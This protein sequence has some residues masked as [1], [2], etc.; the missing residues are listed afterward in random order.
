MGTVA[1]LATI[2]SLVYLYWA[3]R[4]K[5]ICFVFGIISSS[6]WAFESFVHLQLVFDAG[7][8]LFYIVMSMVG[9]YRWKYG[10]KEDTERP[11]TT[12]SASQHIVFIIAGILASGVLMYMSRYIEAIA[13][14]RLDAVTTVFLVIGT[15]LLVDRRLYSWAYL[16]V[17]DVIYMY[18]YGVQEAWLFV[19]MMAVFTV[20][21]I[22]GL[23]SWQKLYLE[24]PIA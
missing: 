5:A 4:N 23:R 22:V 11:I 9:L 10:G 21:G 19:G 17:C 6:F 3:I 8:Q 7:L 1:W 16:V 2:F 14:P 15:I 20:F 12:L 24:K 13:L 18:I